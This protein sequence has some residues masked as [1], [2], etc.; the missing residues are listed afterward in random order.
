MVQYLIAVWDY[1]AEG[2][3]ELSFKQGDRIKLLEKHND[4]WWEGELNDEIGFFPAN[5]IRLE[6]EQEAQQYEPVIPQQLL[7]EQPLRRPNF[8]GAN[9][10][11]H[12]QQRPYSAPDDITRFEVNHALSQQQE[13]PTPAMPLRDT[14]KRSS[15][16][17]AGDMETAKNENN[18]YHLNKTNIPPVNLPEGWQHAYDDDGTIYF[19][20]EHTGESRWEKPEHTPITTM[21]E[22]MAL[23]PP[24]PTEEISVELEQGLH[25][26]RPSELAQLELNNLQPDW[27]RHMGY[28][29]MKMAAEKEEGGKLSSWKMY[30][31]VLSK[32]FLLL[33]KDSYSKLK[34]G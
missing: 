30:Y 29:Q 27:I 5:R 1:A 20:N 13:H 10:G 33:Y 19:F 15:Y 25:K 24:E 7:T 22:N 4:D 6:T 9:D 16:N 12:F 17:E 18:P 32:G 14:G 23:T 2:E 26:L 3:F 21:L 31:G 28:I 34:V 11:F 8:A